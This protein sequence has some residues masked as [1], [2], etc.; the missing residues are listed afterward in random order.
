V[1]A[2]V[3]AMVAILGVAAVTAGIV[4]VGIEGRGRFRAPRLADRM[5]RAAEHLNGDAQQLH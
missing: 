2:I 1:T 3:I 5:A 4:V